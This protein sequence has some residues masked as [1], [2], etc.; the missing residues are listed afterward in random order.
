MLR[1]CFRSLGGLACSGRSPCRDRPRFRRP[2]K[3]KK[4]QKTRIRG[5]SF[6]SV[7]RG[8][9]VSRKCAH[10]DIYIYIYVP[11]SCVTG[12]PPPPPRWYGLCVTGPPLPPRWYGPLPGGGVSSESSEAKGVPHLRLLCSELCCW[13]ESWSLQPPNTR[14]HA[15]FLHVNRY[16]TFSDA[17]HLQL[18]V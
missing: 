10:Q 3:V 4:T 1:V 17:S 7:L 18:T 13:E 16:V 5:T 12:P 11:A 8:F 14:C 9:Y 15:V 6:F 2:S